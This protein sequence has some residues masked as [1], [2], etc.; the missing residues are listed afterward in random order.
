MSKQVAAIGFPTFKCPFVIDVIN[1]TLA[2]LI[3]NLNSD[4]LLSFF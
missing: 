3:L 4:V 2:E 1:V